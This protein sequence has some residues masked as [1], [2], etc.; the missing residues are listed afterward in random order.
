M[1]CAVWLASI[2]FN[3]LSSSTHTRDAHTKPHN[4]SHTHSIL[5]IVCVSAAAAA[6]TADYRK[7]QRPRR[8]IRAS[9]EIFLALQSSYIAFWQCASNPG[10]GARSLRIYKC[11]R[12]A[13]QRVQIDELNKLRRQVVCAIHISTPQCDGLVTPPPPIL[14]TWFCIFIK[15]NM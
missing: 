13:A 12:D 7:G 15:H 14:Y 10:N 11:L 9:D 2:G 5:Y 4:T 3:H 6:A 1:R 8:I